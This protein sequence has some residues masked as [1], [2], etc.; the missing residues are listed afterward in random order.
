MGEE[1][2]IVWKEIKTFFYWL[3]WESSG[4]EWIKNISTRNVL[5]LKLIFIVLLLSQ[6]FHQSV[7][8]MSSGGHQL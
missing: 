4:T 2:V 7:W 3:S 8:Q 6:Y 5:T 1:A